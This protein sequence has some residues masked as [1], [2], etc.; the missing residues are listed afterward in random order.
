MVHVAEA[1]NGRFP[2]QRTENLNA[3]DAVTYNLCM[4]DNIA[5]KPKSGQCSHPDIRTQRY[6]DSSQSLS[7]GRLQHSMHCEHLRRLGCK[8]HKDLYLLRVHF[9]QG[10]NTEPQRSQTICE[11]TLLERR[12][13]VI[14]YT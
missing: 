4:P 3:Q 1:V 8:A 5:P 10:N 9:R 14:G 13:R 11:Y 2:S 7:K 12:H 6:Q